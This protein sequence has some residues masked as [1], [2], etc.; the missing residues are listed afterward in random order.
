MKVISSSSFFIHLI[1]IAAD[2]FEKI[3]D[4]GG[5]YQFQDPKAKDK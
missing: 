3:Q 2:L 4:P 1:R 5:V